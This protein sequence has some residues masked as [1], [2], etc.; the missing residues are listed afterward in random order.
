MSD[1]FKISEAAS[2]GMHAMIHLAAHPKEK[3]TTRQIADRYKISEHHLAKVMQ[4]LVKVGLVESSRGPGGG[5]MISS[6]KRRINLLQ[7]YE[8]IEGRL[9]ARTCLLSAKP[10]CKPDECF[11]GGLNISIHEQIKKHFQDTE[12]L[13]VAHST[14]ENMKI[15]RPIIEIDEE[16]C[17]GCG[18]CVPSCAEGAIAIVDGKAKLVKDIYCDGLGACLGDCPEG[19]LTVIEREADAFDEKEVEAYL[20]KQKGESS[21]PVSL[22]SS[23]AGCSGLSERVILKTDIV[24]GADEDAVSQLGHW[25][26]QIKLVSPEAPFLK[27]ADLLICADCVPFALPNFHSRY[28]KGKAVVVGCPKL[29]D[30]D[31]YQQRFTEI[32]LHAK[33]A[34]VTVLRMTVPCCGGLT[35]AVPEAAKAAGYDIPIEVHTIG[36]EGDIFKK[37]TL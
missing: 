1:L 32:F 5:F 34:S 12:L 14:G 28:L 15:K 26:V 31:F 27:G 35:H 23:V 11:F 10:L 9:E 13:A 2:I 25:P 8:A 3:V 30:L 33:P 17:T 22:S 29:D 24:T 19:A 18:L 20:A 4:K 21:E 6:H 37:E 7:I 36:I 16:K